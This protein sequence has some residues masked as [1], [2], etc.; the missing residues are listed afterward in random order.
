MD[1]HAQLQKNP[2]FYQ[3]LNE[4]P[5][6]IGHLFHGLGGQ[7]LVQQSLYWLTI[8]LSKSPNNKDMR[9]ANTFILQLL[10]N[11]NVKHIAINKWMQRR[12][13]FFTGPGWRYV[14]SAFM[15]TVLCAA[16]IQG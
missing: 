2:Y 7:I 4:F 10:F 1:Y 14:Q 6:Q 16:S 5:K 13:K 11:G 15:Y 12:E 8:T 3:A 9:E